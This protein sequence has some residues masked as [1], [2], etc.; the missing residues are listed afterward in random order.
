[1]AALKRLSVPGKETFSHQLHSDGRLS[2]SLFLSLSFSLSLS[3]FLSE[4]TGF[5]SLV[6]VEMEGKAKNRKRR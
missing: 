4:M 5:H 1:M 6:L 2:L 3:L